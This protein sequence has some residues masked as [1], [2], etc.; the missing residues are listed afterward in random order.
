MNGLAE[1]E[2][3]HDMKINPTKA[4]STILGYFQRISSLWSGKSGLT[5]SAGVTMP[6]SGETTPLGGTG[7]RIS[8]GEPGTIS[9]ESPGMG[10]RFA[11]F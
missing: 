7:I 3:E 9:C 2:S 10:M 4:M 5:C 8:S 6:E 1:L 11:S